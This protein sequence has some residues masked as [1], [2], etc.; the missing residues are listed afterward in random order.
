MPIYLEYGR[1]MF[2]D[3]FGNPP[4]VI[5][6]KITN[7]NAFG[8]TTNSKFVFCWTPFNMGCSTINS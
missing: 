1:F 4:I 7:G 5:F 6:F 3:V 2:L 8:S